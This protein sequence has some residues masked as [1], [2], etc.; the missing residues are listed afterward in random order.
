MELPAQDVQKLPHGV[1][2]KRFPGGF[3]AAPAAMVKKLTGLSEN[4]ARLEAA[5]P[6][7]RPSCLGPAVCHS[8][9]GYQVWHLWP[10]TP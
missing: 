2:K 6:P 5:G 8:I 7:E 4:E 1:G 9:W 3:L 10:C